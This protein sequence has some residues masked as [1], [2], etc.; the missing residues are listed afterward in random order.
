MNKLIPIRAIGSPW[1]GRCLD[2]IYELGPFPYP[3]ITTQPAGALWGP[4]VPVVHPNAPGVSK[5]SAGS[6]RAWG[7]YIGHTRSVNGADGGIGIGA[8]RWLYCDP[9]TD[10]TWLMRL[11]IT[12]NTVDVTMEVWLDGVFG[13]FRPDNPFNI[14]PR[15]VQSFT[16]TP[17][18]PTWDTWSTTAATVVNHLRWKTDGISHQEMAISRDGSEVWV[19]VLTN[20]GGVSSRIY[21]PTSETGHYWGLLSGVAVCSIVKIDM[22]GTST[23]ELSGAAITATVGKDILYQD[24]PNGMVTNYSRGATSFRHD[25]IFYRTEDGDC[26][27]EYQFTHA[28]GVFKALY[29]LWA[30]SWGVSSATAVS[31]YGSGTEFKIFAQN[32]IYVSTYSVGAVNND[33]AEAWAALD[34]LGVTS[35]PHDDVSTWTYVAPSS[36][37]H[38]HPSTRQW[39]GTFSPHDVASTFEIH[40]Y[41]YPTTYSG[42][43]YQWI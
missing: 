26:T 9:V 18:I 16:W 1:H 28:T 17:D 8:D 34:Y 22:V 7:M 37:F 43:T 33:F 2:D 41:T 12:V 4:A 23:A 27:R 29:A 24:G 19:H 35:L 3:T 6:D 42:T 13:R 36:A 25:S 20:P 15:L 32:A 21:C 40:D 38:D 14:T 31:A 5:L 30:A 11:E 10:A 39:V